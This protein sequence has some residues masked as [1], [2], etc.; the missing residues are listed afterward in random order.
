MK[1][2]EIHKYLAYLHSCYKADNRQLKLVD[3]LNT[4]RVEDFQF[5]EGDEELINNAAPKLALDPDYA[6]AISKIAELYQKEKELLYGSLFLLGSRNVLGKSSKVCAPVLL[7]P[8]R[9]TFER[10]YYFLYIDTSSPRL[11]TAI[12]E[13]LVGERG[14]TSEAEILKDL[15]K[16][17]FDYGAIGHLTRLLK[18]H[19]SNLDTEALL[20]YPELWSG[21]KIKRQLQPKQREVMSSFKLIPASGVGIVS[22]SSNTYG[23]LSELEELEGSRSYSRPLQSVFGKSIK[24]APANNAKPHIPAILNKAQ[25]R[26]V[27]NARSETLS[28]IVGPPGTGKSYTIA[29]MALDHLTRG[30]SVLISSKQDEAVDVVA[31]KIEELLH[32]DEVMIR[33]GAKNNLRKMKAG[34]RKMLSQTMTVDRYGLSG[35]DITHL[36]KKIEA[37]ENELSSRFEQELKWSSHLVSTKKLSQKLRASI[38]KILH[39]RYDP[40]WQLLKE[41]QDLLQRRIDDGREAIY[42]DYQKGVFDLLVFDRKTLVKLDQGLRKTKSIDR[43]SIYENLN[44]DVLLKAFPIWLCKLADLY[45]I[46]PQEKELFDLVIIDEASQCDMATTMAAIQRAKRVVLCGDPNQLRHT[47]FLSKMKMVQLLESSGLPSS[48]I[49]DYNFRE[50]SILDLV[51][52]KLQSQTQVTFLDEHYRSV[53]EIIRFS[54]EHFYSSALRVM[55]ERPIRSEGLGQ[56]EIKLNGNR[57]KQGINQVE[58]EEIVKR[59]KAVIDREQTLSPSLKSSIGILSPFRDQ[60]EYI[61]NRISTE[62]E[63]LPIQDHRIAVGTAYAFQGEERDIMFLSFALSNTSHHSAFVHLN[64]ADVFNV[65]ITRAKSKQY[66]VHSLEIKKLS[67][68]HYVR[69]FLEDVGKQAIPKAENEYTHDLFLKEVQEVLEQLNLNYWTYYSIAG[70][71]LDL[72]VKTETGYKG[73]DLIGYPGKYE[74]ALTVERFKIL[75]RAGIMVFPLPY[76]FWLLR[77]DQCIAELK[78]FLRAN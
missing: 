3:F 73:I 43:D 62:L 16:F 33:G 29:C 28:M 63:I 23:I 35:S 14:T 64:K 42:N 26:A 12:L 22:K 34:L 25:Q 59:V 68:D 57:N 1:N 7:F 32:T 77:Q 56:F 54:N 15:P 39:K 20:L 60:A 61:F 41:L 66:L 44:Y 71:P 65:A 5:I 76:S 31:K 19:F 38:I 58:A 70:V 46:L 9:V 37:L 27:L 48:A 4:N 52:G 69:M 2:T 30:E 17:P 53:P 50:T 72:L 18:K 74:D 67:R 11:N 45:R 36:N 49:A 51:S 8:A 47:S 78:D 21:K 55:N 6:R 75:G 10:G 40:H 24:K 13:L